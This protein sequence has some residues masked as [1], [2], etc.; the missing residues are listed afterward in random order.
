MGERVVGRGKRLV[1]RFPLVVWL[2]LVWV[3]LWGTYDLG[4]LFFGIVVAVFVSGL[5]PVPP[6]TTNIAPRPVRLLSVVLYLAWD[7]VIST[8]R[9]AWQAIRYGRRA[10]AGIVAVR[11]VTDSD[12]IIA[13]VA[14][15]VS[16][17]PGNAVVQIDRA[18]R[19]FFVYSL[20]LRSEE[21]AESVR[22][23]VRYLEE[24]IVRAVGSDADVAGIDAAGKEG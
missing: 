2:A 4:T 15:A 20:G 14:Q 22:R 18:N 9:V 17:A 13:M 10:T 8:V 21:E 23:E 3:M 24:K 12:H 11:L 7:L 1:Q 5:F 6:I 16:L 19:V